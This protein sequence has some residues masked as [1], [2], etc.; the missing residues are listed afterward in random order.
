LVWRFRAAPA[1]RLIGAYGQLESIWPVHGAVLIQNDTLYATAGRSSY[2]D[3]GIVLYRLDPATGRE[4]SKTTLYHLDPDTG[5]QRVPEARFNMEGTTADILS[6]DGELVFL[7]YFSFDRAGNR[8][9]TTQPH[10]FS[11]TGLLG[12]D[13][14]VRTYWVIGQDMPAAG[15]SGWA[16]AANQFPS[17]Q[18]LSFTG[19]TVYG[20]GREKLAG[21]PVGHRADTYRLFGRDRTS[22]PRPAAKRAKRKSSG[23]GEFLWTDPQSLIIRAMV[24][25]KDRLAVAGP[26]DLGEKDPNLLA[27]KNEPEARAGFEGRK[28]VY[29]R[30]VNA[31][32][33]SRISESELPAMP[34]FDG[35]STASGRLYLSTL[36]GQVLCLGA[37][38]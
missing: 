29:L 32:D 10:L 27:F 24:L 18:I 17:G 21:G 38:P 25:G 4:L 1:E 35:L 36:D 2:L 16:N 31:A 30:T 15:W 12:E 26:R 6:G 5:A 23:D 22:E 7:K 28:G 8:T 20:Y 37:K 9:E 11:I 19:D 14:F 34:V 13:W 33:G 3:G